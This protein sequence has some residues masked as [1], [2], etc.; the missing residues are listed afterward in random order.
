M[1]FCLGAGTQVTVLCG[2]VSGY[3]VAGNSSAA[4][5]T[6]DRLIARGVLGS[7]ELSD[8]GVT[9]MITRR[10]LDAFLGNATKRA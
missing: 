9:E 7:Y 2:P 3:V 5:E 4:T 10:D 6:A 1:L 8:A